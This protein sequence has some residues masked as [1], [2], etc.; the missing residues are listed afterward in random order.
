MVCHHAGTIL[1]EQFVLPR[2]LSLDELAQAIDVPCVHVHEIIHGTQAITADMDARLCAFFGLTAG[3]FLTLQ[4]KYDVHNTQHTLAEILARITPHHS[5]QVTRVAVICGGPSP[6]R[7]ISLNSAR[8]VVDHLTSSTI[9]VQIVYVDSFCHFYVLSTAQ[10]YS[11]TPSDFDFKLASTARQLSLAEIILFLRQFDIVFPVIHGTFGEDGKLQALLEKHDIAFVGSSSLTCHTMFDKDR[12][13]AMLKR[14][15]YPTL[16]TI[17]VQKGSA[18]IEQALERFFAT[19]ALSKVVIKPIAGGSSI[20]VCTA[21]SPQEALAKTQELF[22]NYMYEEALIEPFCQGKEFTVI[23]LQNE[24]G[25]PV[26]LIPTEIQVSYENGGFFDYRRKYLPTTN[27][28]WFCPPRFSSETITTIRAQAEEIFSVF[29]MR[30]FARLDGWVLDCGT[31]LFSDLNPISGMEQNSFIFQQAARIGLSHHEL[32]THILRH[33]C[34]RSGIRAPACTPSSAQG[35]QPVWVI[36]GG[37]T[38]ERQVSLLSGT[39]V[40]L[41]LRNSTKYAPHPYVLDHNNRVWKLPYSYALNHTVEE[42][43]DTC[44]MAHI[45]AH[46]ITEHLQ[47]IQARLTYAPQTFQPTE[48]IP[49]SSSL[50]EFIA[51]A[52]QA[53]AIVFIALHGGEGE[54]GTL[55]RAL[56]QAGVPYNGSGSAASF[57]CMD[58]YATGQIISELNDPLIKTVPKRQFRVATLQALSYASMV[59]LWNEMTEDLLSKTLLVKPQRDGCSAGIVRLYTADELFTYVQLL[60][61]H[62]SHIPPH[63]FSHQKTPIDLPAQCEEIL[64]EQFIETDSLICHKNEL[65]YHKTTGWVEVTCGVLEH[66][67]NYHALQPSIT[68]ATG[69]VLSVEEKFQGGTGINITPPPS[70]I[71]SADRIHILQQHVERIAKALGIAQYAR[72]DL[73]F[74]TDSGSTYVIE[75]NTLPALTPSTVIYQQALCEN[76]PLFPKEFLEKI[77]AES[78][79]H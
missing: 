55:Q 79:V 13:A 46:R 35:K 22:A 34:A 25:S 20:G 39:N 60:T 51:A 59:A 76:P 29:G 21:T 12:A 74:H 50:E 23:V 48:L 3:F 72:L 70:T 66:Q 5:S 31:I 24:D 49:S 56:S 9:N 41:K 52:K 10:L 7:G 42:I 16:P 63:T 44:Q 54:N 2:A 11:N 19:H 75:A 17:A 33:A 77:V 40:W 14:H 26:A 47:D 64:L 43:I 69:N 30:D 61:T 58:K 36:C 67:G 18:R 71:M 53:N 62:C 65:S 8:S 78:C 1:H 57:V 4:V 73:F 38:A 45:H 28:H 37:P 15:G 27:T 68:V 6:E 32:L